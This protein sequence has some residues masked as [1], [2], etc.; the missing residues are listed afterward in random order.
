MAKYTPFRFFVGKSPLNKIDQ[1]YNSAME[2]AKHILVRMGENRR[3]STASLSE[4]ED[5][6]GELGGNDGT[7]ANGNAGSL[8]LGNRRNDSPV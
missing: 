6:E 7:W 2:R 1:D 3:T 8:N 5:G 4:L